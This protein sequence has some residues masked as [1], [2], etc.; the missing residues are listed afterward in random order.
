MLAAIV[1]HVVPAPR[2]ALE[3]NDFYVESTLNRHCEH[4]EATQGG[5][6]LRWIASLCPQ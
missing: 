3:R 1:T 2:L 6:M 4:S 5:V